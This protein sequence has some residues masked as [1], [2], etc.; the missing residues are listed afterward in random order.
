[1]SN[2]TAQTRRLIYNALS[3][4]ICLIILLILIPPPSW[5][6]VKNSIEAEIPLVWS[7]K[8]RIPAN[9]DYVY[10]HEEWANDCFMYLSWPSHY[11][12]EN[13]PGPSMRWTN[14]ADKRDEDCVSWHEPSDP[15]MW[16]DNFM[17]LPKDSN[18]EMKFSVADMHDIPGWNKAEDCVS[19]DMPLQQNHN[20]HDNY[21]CVR[22][23]GKTY[24]NI[25][26]SQIEGYQ[27][28]NQL[29]SVEEHNQ[30]IQS[31]PLCTD[32]YENEINTIK[33]STFAASAGPFIS[34]KTIVYYGKSD[35]T[36]NYDANK[37]FCNELGLKMKQ[38]HS[39]EEYYGV[40]NAFETA[41][42]DLFSPNLGYI[43]VR[44]NGQG[45]KNDKRNW[46]YES[47][48]TMCYDFWDGPSQ[49]QSS[50]TEA[51]AKPLRLSNDANQ[52]HDVPCTSSYKFYCEYR[53]RIE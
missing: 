23:K 4:V 49:P 30:L 50:G 20:W 8:D 51:C 47:G 25:H 1:M 21:F 7:S 6:P 52:L 10:V 17:C 29:C 44:Y 35:R 18:Y 37:A 39:S 15:D 2:H 31:Y 9:H 19:V 38:I 28:Q 33:G 24:S 3:A 45:S 12:K 43:G 32:Q 36:G 40:Y 13:H 26:Q 22:R 48:H 42:N 27:L 11:N 5:G 41:Q 16:H 53:C 34:D 14:V 46:K